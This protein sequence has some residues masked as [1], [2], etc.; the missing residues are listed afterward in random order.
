MKTHAQQTQRDEQKHGP[1][2][3]LRNGNQLDE[4][5]RDS[6]DHSATTTSSRGDIDSLTNDDDNSKHDRT[7][8]NTSEH[9]SGTAT[10]KPAA[11]RRRVQWC[12]P[13]CTTHASTRIHHE[14]TNG[15][16][17]KKVQASRPVTTGWQD[18]EI[19]IQK[20]RERAVQRAQKRRHRQA[21]T[22]LTVI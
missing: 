14:N 12:K 9:T 10:D 17:P 22:W 19:A 21:T 8:S 18:S 11:S 20:A 15:K 13:I 3:I 16:Q 7:Q 2:T 6:R 5:T 1:R 4:S